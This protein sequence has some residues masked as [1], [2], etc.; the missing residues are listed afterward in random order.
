[1][2]PSAGV[3]D[4]VLTEPTEKGYEHRDI[5]ALHD[6]LTQELGGATSGKD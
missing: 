5:A 3:A 2:L 4:E 6:L 1:M